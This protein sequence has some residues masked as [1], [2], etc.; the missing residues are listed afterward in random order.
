MPEIEEILNKVEELREKLNKLA[1][2][3][4]EKLTDPKIIAVSR[5]LDILLNTYHKLMTN[6]MIKLKSQ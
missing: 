5:E 1:Q 6:K 4:N 3:K 2:N